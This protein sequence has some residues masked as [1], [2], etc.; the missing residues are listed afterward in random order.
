MIR[1]HIVIIM[2]T[3]MRATVGIITPKVSAGAGTAIR[4]EV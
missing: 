1:M 2:T 3:T 4:I